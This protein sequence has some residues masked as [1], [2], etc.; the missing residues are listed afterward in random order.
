MC[1]CLPPPSLAGSRFRITDWATGGEAG[2]C[3]SAPRL[4]PKALRLYA[5]TDAACDARQVPIQV[6]GDVDTSPGGELR[7]QGT[8]P[9]LLHGLWSGGQWRRCRGLH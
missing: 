2:A 8:S 6:E 7:L 9:P 3:D 1:A 5:V 4:P